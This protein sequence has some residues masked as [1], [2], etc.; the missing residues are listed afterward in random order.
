MVTA[1][2]APTLPAASALTYIIQTAMP[3]GLK[4]LAIAAMLAVIMSSVDSFLNSIA[5]TFSQDILKPLGTFLT[6]HTL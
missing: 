1:I 2:L 5:L 4:G 3:I 6:F